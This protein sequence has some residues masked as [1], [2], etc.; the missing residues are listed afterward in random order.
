MTD[1]TIVDLR[2]SDL[3][4]DQHWVEDNIDQG[5]KR[6]MRI[7]PR[8]THAVATVPEV[9]DW[10]TDLVTAAAKA[11]G[12]N[13]LPKIGQGP[14]LLLLGA[15][16]T[17]KTWQAYGAIR[18]L[19]VSGVSCSWIVAPAADIYA[20]MR[21]R[22]GLDSEAVFEKYSRAQLL[23]VDDLGAAKNSEWVEEVNYRLI[24][25]RYEHSLP[26]LI[27][28][29]LTPGNLRSELGER[30]SSRL[31]EMCQRVV[32]DGPDRRRSV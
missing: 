19:A 17:G 23:V 7:P 8:Y 10:I 21:P 25:F 3:P 24:N 30:V 13:N 5:S 28:S 26:T 14:S 27:T 18:G 2:D 31:V 22:S 4:L 32:L 29:N 12:P 15:V 6:L 16:G 11:A 20:S 9:R 1:P